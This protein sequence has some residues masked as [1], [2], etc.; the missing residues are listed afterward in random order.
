MS[1]NYAIVCT[2]FM[3]PGLAEPV[4]SFLSYHLAVGFDHIYLF[5]DDPS[6][7]DVVT[8]AE[9]FGSSVSIFLRGES[10]LE[11]QKAVCSLYS[12]LESF[13]SCDVPARQMVNA[14]YASILATNSGF[15]WLLHIDVD[16]V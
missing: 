9:H 2:V 13:L 7:Q 4:H 16:E 10:L 3:P 15:K 12:R 6:N 8:I 5:L 11:K 14:E 1:G